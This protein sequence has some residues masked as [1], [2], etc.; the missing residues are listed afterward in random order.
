MR[1]MVPKDGNHKNLSADNWEVRE[2]T[3]DWLLGRSPPGMEDEQAVLSGEA[4]MQKMEDAGLWDTV[5]IFAAAVLVL[6]CVATFL[7]AG[8]P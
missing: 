5:L 3:A 4:H 7:G 1:V 6:Y 2:V 8:Q